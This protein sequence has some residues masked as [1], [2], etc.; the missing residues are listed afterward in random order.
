[1]TNNNDEKA[2]EGSGN[3]VPL[4]LI[5]L[6]S[7]LGVA[8]ISNLDKIYP[9]PSVTVSPSATASAELPKLSLSPE[10]SPVLSSL[11][12]NPSSESIKTAKSPIPDSAPIAT[13]K[14]PFSGEIV[15]RSIEASGTLSSLATG[16]SLWIYIEP[17]A[18]KKYYPLQATYDPASKLWKASIKVGADEKE[19]SGASFEIGIFIA[20]VKIS[21]ELSDWRN[22]GTSKLPAD[23]VRLTSLPVLVK[24]K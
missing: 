22:S 2:K 21:Q 1:M 18:Q 15:D 10:P 23:I 24:R 20:N 7:T 8:T 14:Q 9:K 17:L 11:P 12:S 16:N 5:G 6:V 19:E 4:A 3:A 13:I